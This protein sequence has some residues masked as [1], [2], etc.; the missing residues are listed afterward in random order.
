MAAELDMWVLSVSMPVG[1]C[2]SRVGR[3]CRSLFHR[4]TWISQER[5]SRE[6]EHRSYDGRHILSYAIQETDSCRKG[7]Y[8]N[9][10]YF[11]I[12]RIMSIICIMLFMPIMLIIHITCIVLNIHIIL[13]I[14]WFKF[15][16]LVELGLADHVWQNQRAAIAHWRPGGWRFGP[17]VLSSHA[18]WL[19][20]IHQSH[21]HRL[22]SPGAGAAATGPSIGQ[23]KVVVEDDEWWFPACA[24]SKWYSP[25]SALPLES[26]EA[27]L[28]NEYSPATPFLIC[29][30]CIIAKTIK[31]IVEQ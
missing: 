2:L 31:I 13:I 23:G 11:C 9:Y 16:A 28:R 5:V 20:W 14:L 1:L 26:L 6:Q 19:A 17:S 24:P 8:V 12:I 7:N 27:D 4:W 22:P 30:E 3:A 15:Q 18:Q 21:I 10:T 29:D 25:A